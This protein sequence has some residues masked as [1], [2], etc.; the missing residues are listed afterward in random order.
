MHHTVETLLARAIPE[1]NTGCWIW[2]GA[3]AGGTGYPVTHQG[4][5]TI[6]AHR[7]MA[8]FLFGPVPSAMDACH[9]CD[10]RACINP[11]HLFLGTRAENLADM[12]AK[13]RDNHVKGERSPKAKL[14]AK[15]VAEIKRSLATGAH[16]SELALRYGVTAPVVYNIKAGRAWKHITEAA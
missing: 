7:L 9:R 14:T 1:P 12:R 4:R 6:G 10:V 8:S 13:G 11:E 3:L 5:R 16:P 15:S 2:M